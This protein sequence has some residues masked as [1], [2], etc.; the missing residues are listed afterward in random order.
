MVPGVITKV[1]VEVAGS[2]VLTSVVITSSPKI[3]RTGP[4]M[5]GFCP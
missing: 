2:N 5:F 1:L 4:G 3:L